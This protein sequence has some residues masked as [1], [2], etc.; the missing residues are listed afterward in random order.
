MTVQNTLVGVFR[1]REPCH[2]LTTPIIHPFAVQTM[3]KHLKL[4]SPDV[5]ASDPIV[6]IANMI[7]VRNPSPSR[8]DATFPL[9][10]Q[11]DNPRIGDY[12]G[13]WS[14]KSVKI[15]IN[16]Q[17]PLE[18]IREIAIAIKAFNDSISGHFYIDLDTVNLV[19]ERPSLAITKQTDGKNV[20]GIATAVELSQTWRRSILTLPDGITRIYPP[21]KRDVATPDSL[22]RPETY[23]FEEIDIALNFT[24]F[25][26]G[27][28]LAGLIPD[29]SPARNLTWIIAHE[30]GHFL[31]LAHIDPVMGEPDL[32]NWRNALMISRGNP[33]DWLGIPVRETNL[34]KNWYK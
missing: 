29:N 23:I 16:S 34:L 28:L 10:V 6:S 2:S 24:A 3:G 25:V 17:T 20:I 13:K 30:L 4:P 11:Q 19:S 18:M 27:R 21:I 33:K 22:Q 32:V 12:D 5:L 8:G 26:D 9:I 15:F 1:G 14:Q 31:G 7:T